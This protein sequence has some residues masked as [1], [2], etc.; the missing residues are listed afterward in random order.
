[1]A[2]KTTPDEEQ[3]LSSVHDDPVIA[4]EFM[5]IVSM[6]YWV[7]SENNEQTLI[8]TSLN[9]YLPDA[10]MQGDE[11]CVMYGL[12]PGDYAKYF[13]WV[14]EQRPPDKGSELI[15]RLNAHMDDLRRAMPSIK[16][17]GSIFQIEL[18][19]LTWLRTWHTT[20]SPTSRDNAYN[21][22]RKALGQLKALPRELMTALRTETVVPEKESIERLQKIVQQLTGRPNLFVSMKDTKRLREE[23]PELWAQY[24]EARKPLTL[25]FKQY[26]MNHVRDMNAGEPMDVHEVR[27]HFESNKLPHFLPPKEFKGKIGDTGALFTSHGKQLDKTIGP[28]VEV[29]MNPMYNPELDGQAKVKNN[30]YAALTNPTVDRHGNNN[31]AYMYTLDQIKANKAARFELISHM[32]K[33]ERKMMSAWRKDLRGRD[34]NRK[35]LAAMCEIVYLTASRIG[36]KDNGTVDEETFGLSTLSVGNVKRRGTSVILEYVGKKGVHQTHKISPTTPE[37]TQVVNVINTLMEGKRRADLLW[38]YD[39]EVY[40]PAKVNKYFKQVTGIGDATIH[41]LRHVRGTGIALEIL[42]KL[43]EDLRKKRNLSNKMVDDEFKAALTKVGKLLGHV[44][45]IDGGT[46]IEWSTAAKNY[47]D[48]EV[49]RDFYANFND[50][51]FRPAKAIQS[52]LK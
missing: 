41:K 43:A 28:D 11:F 44:K 32:I 21:N 12:R 29:R 15:E 19:L 33:N 4:Y 50:L 37:E 2:T 39:G 5:L 52:V 20:K 1:M 24:L 18:D 16:A 30:Y 40:T 25:F 23:K 22:I 46:K 26:L 8:P 42:P 7:K 45:G 36:G 47:V 14:M 9:Q 10:R 6:L 17:D 13:D 35:V 51:G 49:L 34:W 48:P 3:A 38:E 31:T 27:K